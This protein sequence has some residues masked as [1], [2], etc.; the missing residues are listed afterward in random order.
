[1]ARVGEQ[2]KA[3]AEVLQQI[4][5]ADAGAVQGHARWKQGKLR[6]WSKRGE[7]PSSS[8]EPGDKVS[9]CLQ[10]SIPT[11]V[12]EMLQAEAS[13]RVDSAATR[14][15]KA[16]KKPKTAQEYAQ[17]STASKEASELLEEAAALEAAAAACAEDRACIDL[18][19]RN[20]SHGQSCSVPGLHFTVASASACI[21]VSGLPHIVVQVQQKTRGGYDGPCSGY[22]GCSGYSDRKHEAYG[23]LKIENPMSSNGYH[24]YGA[25]PLIF[26]L[27][28]DVAQALRGAHEIT[29]QAMPRISTETRT[30]RTLQLTDRK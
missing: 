29:A 11:L 21:S 5:E 17:V 27:A 14:I 12:V 28:H 9:L 19:S 8:E 1:M 22:G 20:G 25:H 7:H 3:N 18:S 26:A 13:L 16:P 6:I 2:S 24:R 10:R 4:A 15:Q 23:Y 30:F